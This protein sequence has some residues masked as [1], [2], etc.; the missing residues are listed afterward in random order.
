MA[1]LGQTLLYINADDDPTRLY[2]LRPL[3]GEVLSTQTTP[4][5]TYDGLA[6]DSGAIFLGREGID[7]RRQKA[8]TRPSVDGWALGQP[9]GAMGGDDYDRVFGFFADGLIHEVDTLG[10]TGVYLGSVTPPASDI[11][12]LAWDSQRL[13]A[14]T[15]SGRLYTLRLDP[16]AEGGSVVLASVV[17]PGGPLFGLA[18]AME[19][20]G[21]TSDRVDE[22]EPNNS[23]NNAQNLDNAFQLEFNRDIGDEARNTSTEIPH[24]SV[25]GSGDNSFD[26]YSF[27][28]PAAGSR[29][30]F[31]IDDTSQNPYIDAHLRLYDQRRHAACR[32]QRQR[33]RRRGRRQ[34]D[35]HGFLPAVHVRGTWHVRYR[36]GKL[37]PESRAREHELPPARLHRKPCHAA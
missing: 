15:S 34:H 16:A 11:E 27:T 20:V 7:I 19:T 3:T 10:D 26:Y 31:D 9:V 1:E 29:G 35:Q 17:V 12:G 24:V 13:Y 32:E 2:R 25:R 8:S 14:S 6:Y 28:V 4:A 23:R 37:L 33:P 36:G 5:G 21:G 22:R 18:A 30:I